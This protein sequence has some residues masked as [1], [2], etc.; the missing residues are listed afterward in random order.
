MSMTDAGS[1]NAGPAAQPSPNRSQVGAD[2]LLRR[3]S[4]C[5]QP[6]HGA[7]DRGRRAFGA[8]TH[9]PVLPGLRIAAG[10]RVGAVPRGIAPGG[11]GRHQPPDR[12]ERHRAAGCRARG[13]DREPEHRQGHGGD[14]DLRGCRRRLQR[15]S[16]RDRQHRELPAGPGGTT[17]RRASEGLPRSH[18]AGGRVAHSVRG[19]TAPCGGRP[20][21]QGVGAAVRFP[22]VSERHPRPRDH[23]RAERRGAA[24]PQSLDRRSVREGAAGVRQSHHGRD[25][26]GLRQRD[27]ADRRQEER[28]A[29]VRGH[30]A[31]HPARRHDR[32]ARG[33]RHDSRRLRR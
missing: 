26:D 15:Y 9:R 21:R 18:D 17:G 7:A 27:S 28:R 29:G 4:R 8:S 25:T 6:A 19:R 20:A 16:E 14:G 24:P 30:S 22:G 12:G 10:R 23:D 31:H 5:R 1:S 33:R 2:R 3:Q 32:D 11:R 13:G